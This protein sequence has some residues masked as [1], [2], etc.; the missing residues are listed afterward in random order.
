MSDDQMTTRESVTHFVAN[1]M[2][3]PLAHRAFLRDDAEPCLR[4]WNKPDQT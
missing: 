1:R 3:S 2:R 4:R